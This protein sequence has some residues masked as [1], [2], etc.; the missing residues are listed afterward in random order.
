MHRRGITPPKHLEMTPRAAWNR[1]R[2]HRRQS[3]PRGCPRTARGGSRLGIPHQ[4]ARARLEPAGRGRLV[5]LRLRRH[6]ASVRAGWFAHRR[7]G[8]LHPGR[9]RRARRRSGTAARACS[10]LDGYPHRIPG[11]GAG[12]RACAGRM[13]ALTGSRLGP[14]AA[15]LTP[16]WWRE[17]HPEVL[18]KTA[19]FAL[20]EDFL[21]QRLTGSPLLS[22]PNAS[23]TVAFGLRALD[24]SDRLLGILGL[25]RTAFSPAAPSEP[26][27]VISLETPPEHSGSRR[28]A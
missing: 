9:H 27:R 8:N 4:S 23:R 2:H 13:V 6:P 28:T 1:C 7:P 18:R 25:D 19:R 11:P 26:L 17:S 5:A 10:D 21:V 12:G 14:F 15:A 16:L 22:H 20:V 24:W 3:A